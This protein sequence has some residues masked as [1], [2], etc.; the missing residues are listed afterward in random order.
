MPLETVSRTMEI[1]VPEMGHGNSIGIFCEGMPSLLIDCGTRNRSYIKNFSLLRSRLNPVSSRDLLITHYHY[2]HYNL[3][4]QLP[5]KFF[6]SAHLPALPR[7][8]RTAEVVKQFLCIALVTGFREYYLAPMIVSK[9]KTI[10]CWVKGNSFKAMGRKWEVLWPDYQIIDKMNSRKVEAISKKIGELKERLSDKQREELEEWYGLLSDYLSGEQRDSPN[11]LR[12]NVRK[13]EIDPEVEAA[14]SATE[15]IFKDIANRASIVV[16]D[17]DHDFLFTGDIDDTI[18]NTHLNFGPHDYFL[19]E[20]PHHGGYYGF[21][22]DNV[23]TEVLVISRRK[24]YTPDHRF[25]RNL[26]WKFLVDTARTGNCTIQ[27]T[28]QNR[29]LKLVVRQPANISSYFT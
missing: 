24:N 5:N 7:E 17:E 27:T 14:L 8:S 22:F 21:A 15:D 13:Q 10:H 18:L 20:A 28:R 6:D 3:L 29:Q 4:S 25:F 1:V 12:E 11:S 2:D 19:I 23:S 26:D 16:V 9:A